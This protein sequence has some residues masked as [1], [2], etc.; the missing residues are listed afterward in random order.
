VRCLVAL[1]LL[2][3]AFATVPTFI[4]SETSALGSTHHVMDQ[5]DQEHILH[6]ARRVVGHDEGPVSP[7]LPNIR[8]G[9]P[10]VLVVFLHPKLRTDQISRFSG[11]NAK[12]GLQGGSFKHLKNALS[13]AKSSV[14][15]PQTW[16]HPH[17]HFNKR[18][19]P[20]HVVID[21]PVKQA[22]ATLAKHRPAFSNGKTEILLIRFEAADVWDHKSL[23]AK[24]AK[25]DQAMGH[26]LA[27]VKEATNGN[28]VA[29]F[30]GNEITPLN[31]EMSLLVLPPNQ[32]KFANDFTPMWPDY[33]TP[34]AWKTIIIVAIPIITTVM[35]LNCLTSIQ[36]PDRFQEPK[37]E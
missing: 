2:G 31:A 15:A 13:S 27:S 37:A 3:T 30:A 4:W 24:F 32:L 14:H 26:I 25:D 16:V 33:W 7:H 12:D 6:F 8:P 1:L 21:V 34:P 11:A 9:A 10:E 17:V 18:D 35:A 23:P 36:A 29:M 19:F 28:Y 22:N 5:V 20:G